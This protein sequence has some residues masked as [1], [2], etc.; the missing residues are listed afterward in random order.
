[1]FGLTQA[2]G[3]VVAGRYLFNSVGSSGALPEVAF[4][5]TVT[6]G[7]FSAL[8]IALFVWAI[9]NK[10]RASRIIFKLFFWLVIIGG[11]QIVFSVFLSP[12]SALLLT[13]LLVVLM[14]KVRS[15]LMQNFAVLLAMA[16]MGAVLGLSIS[17]LIA[18]WALLILSFYDIIAVYVTKHMV[19][20]AQ[21][22]AESGAIFGFIVPLK[23]SRF[24]EHVKKIKPGKFM[25]LGS[26]DITL[27]LVMAV[28]A[29]SISMA[30]A[31]IVALF[32]MGGLFLTHLLFVNQTQ[33]RPMAA[34]P[35]IAM[36][37]IVGYLVALLLPF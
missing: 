24:R 4:K 10:H 7:A 17:P 18:V 16:G 12:L 19:K 2:L 9:L 30:H 37:A 28:S 25:I 14:V 8:V 3:I 13:V 31:W 1:M 36:M 34:L 15:V 33:R 11:A 22:M 32:S 35:P 23:W 6:D 20:M 27:P 5:F 26:G 21:G 29:I